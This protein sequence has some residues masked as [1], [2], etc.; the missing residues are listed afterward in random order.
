MKTKI[1][2]IIGLFFATLFLSGCSISN[3]WT[4]FYYKDKDNIGDQKTWVIQP[5]LKSKEE[6][7]NWVKEVAKNNSNYDYECG[8]K[9]RYEKQYDT[10]I[11]KETVK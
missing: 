9:C 6:C 8:Y 1:V 5:G 10:T 3:D 7:Q 4:G 2:A 11:C